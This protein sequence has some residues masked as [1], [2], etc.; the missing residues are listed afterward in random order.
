MV[1]EHYDVFIAYINEYYLFKTLG[2]NLIKLKVGL[3]SGLSAIY[4][5]KSTKSLV[6]S[7]VHFI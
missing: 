1:R 2:D 6:F 5:P 3:S 4:V 7:A